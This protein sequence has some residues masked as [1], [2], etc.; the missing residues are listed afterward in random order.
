MLNIR[1]SVFSVGPTDQINEITMGRTLK[2]LFCPICDIYDCGIHDDD[3]TNPLQMHHFVNPN[4]L[5]EMEDR[6]ESALNLL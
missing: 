6:I 3:I 4:N 2:M 1:S 5:I